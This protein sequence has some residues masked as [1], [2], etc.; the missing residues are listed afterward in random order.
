MEAALARKEH[1]FFV[2][3]VYSGS[4]NSEQNEQTM[5]KMTKMIKM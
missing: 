5:T 2:D 1:F 3:S 4:K